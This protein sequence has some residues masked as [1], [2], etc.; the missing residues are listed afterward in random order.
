MG[1]GEE[2]PARLCVARAEG[3]R[4]SSW[5]RWKRA[6]REVGGRGKSTVAAL[7]AC[8]RTAA[9][10]W[11]QSGH[12]PDQRQEGS[13]RAPLPAQRSVCRLETASSTVLG[14]GQEGKGSSGPIGRARRNW[15]ER[16][17]GEIGRGLVRGDGDP[18]VCGQGYAN[19]VDICDRI[20]R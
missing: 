9:S 5:R 6:V 17:G 14:S 16:S 12:R 2:G 11:K 13:R 3:S 7:A 10:A 19:G 1:E 4:G 20:G 8:H 18:S 15:M